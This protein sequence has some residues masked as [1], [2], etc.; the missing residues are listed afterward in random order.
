MVMVPPSTQSPSM[1]RSRQAL[2]C[3]I[4][5][6]IPAQPKLGYSVRKPPDLSVIT[7]I[8]QDEVSPDRASCTPRPL[9]TARIWPGRAVSPLA[10]SALARAGH[11]ANAHVANAHAAIITRQK[12]LRTPSSL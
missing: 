12:A 6:M 7:R 10:L 9:Q 5:S 3:G 4:F 1:M 11:V 2:E 8:G